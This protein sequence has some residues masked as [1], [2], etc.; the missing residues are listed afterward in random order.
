MLPFGGNCIT[1][2]KQMCYKQCSSYCHFH[3]WQIL[4]PNCHS[5]CICLNVI[6]SDERTEG[7]VL[8]VVDVV[9]PI[10]SS[11]GGFKDIPYR[12]GG[13]YEDVLASEQVEEDC[14]GLQ[15]HGA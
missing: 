7:I 9:G 12:R 10:T 5:P 8:T 14:W 15:V 1:S 13:M 11:Y 4:P 2:K 3:Y 6:V